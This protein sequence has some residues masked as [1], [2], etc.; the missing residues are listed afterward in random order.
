M[1]RSEVKGQ[2]HR[3]QNKFCPDLD[4]I[5]SVFCKQPFRKTKKKTKKTK[6]M[7]SNNNKNF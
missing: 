6:Q 7:F 5:V 4:C 3:G 2:D 1:S